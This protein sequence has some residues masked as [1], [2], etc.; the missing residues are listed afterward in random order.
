[1]QTQRA[2]GGFAK[3][4]RFPLRVAAR[5]ADAL[6][7]IVGHVDDIGHQRVGVFEHHGVD[8]LYQIFGFLAFVAENHQKRGIDVAVG[9]GFV[10]NRIALDAERTANVNDFSKRDHVSAPLISSLAKC[11]G[12]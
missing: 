9:K 1:M 12:L 2:V 10:V 11:A 3:M 8:I 5:F 6:S 4:Q 7:Q